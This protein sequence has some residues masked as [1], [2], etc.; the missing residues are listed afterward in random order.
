M[1][2]YHYHRGVN[3]PS[4]ISWETV[5]VAIVLALIAAAVPVTLGVL[6]NRKNANKKL[7]LDE[8][9]VMLA[10]TGSQIAAYQDLLTRA[11]AAVTKAEGLNGTLEQRVHDLEATRSDQEWQIRTLRN[12]F[13]QVVERSN[14]VLTLQEQEAFDSTKPMEKIR[15]QTGSHFS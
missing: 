5:L 13:T 4:D 2:G 15:R 6:L 1:E 14:I 10:G 7:D 12:L 11:E 3:M 9:T 8:T